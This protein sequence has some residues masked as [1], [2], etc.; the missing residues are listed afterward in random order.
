MPFFFTDKADYIFF[1]YQDKLPSDS[2]K[3]RIKGES[4]YRLNVAAFHWYGLY[5]N[6]VYDSYQQKLDLAND[7]QKYKKIF[8]E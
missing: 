5:R 2:V 6:A 1:Y 3:L 7:I 8:H 4:P